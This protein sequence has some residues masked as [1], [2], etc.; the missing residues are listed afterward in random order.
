M[1]KLG[2]I[3]SSRHF[4]PL[5]V[6]VLTLLLLRHVSTDFFS[7]SNGKVFGS[8]VDVFVNGSQVMLLAL[9][10]TLVIA[11]GG[12]DLSVGAVMA[13]SGAMSAWL[14]TAH[15]ASAG[16]AIA[17]GLA[18]AAVCGLWNGALVAWFGLQPIIATL[19]LMT[20]GRGIAQLITDGTIITFHDAAFE[21][22]DKG[23]L[24]GVPNS[25][26]LVLAMLLVIGAVVDWTNLRLSIESIGSNA[27]ASRVAGVPVSR[28]RLLVYVVSG[29]CAGLAGLI[30]TA[31]ITAA[32]ANNAGLYLEL[33]AILAVVIGGAS[34]SGGRFSLTGALV[35]ALVVQ[36]LTTT[37][38][39]SDVSVHATR[40]VKAVVVV[41]VCLLQSPAFRARLHQMIR[42]RP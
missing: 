23:Y 24:L 31:D 8:L 14:L 32:D 37:I 15:D 13:I 16:A 18:V 22:L 36:G 40:V 39:T 3:V 6:F 11:T 33:D 27:T 4:W 38:L 19:I 28:V 34:L 41:L 7:I 21:A 5:L 20:A 10:M 26:W 2:R 9:G 25:I 42:R 29:L 35:G 30:N 17:G 12:I 1:A